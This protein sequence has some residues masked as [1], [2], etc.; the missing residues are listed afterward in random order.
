MLLLFITQLSLLTDPT[1]E[2][3]TNFSV[4]SDQNKFYILTPESLYI[5]ENGSQWRRKKIEKYRR[6]PVYECRSQ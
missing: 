1:I 5:K 6:C 4:F 2:F 3:S